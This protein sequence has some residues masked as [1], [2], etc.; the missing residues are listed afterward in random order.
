MPSLAEPSLHLWATN[1]GDFGDA[2]ALLGRHGFSQAPPTWYYTEAIATRSV[3]YVHRERPVRIE[4]HKVDLNHWNR[5]PIDQLAVY[6]TEDRPM[7]LY[8]DDQLSRELILHLR[9]PPRIA[10]HLFDQWWRSVFISIVNLVR[11]GFTVVDQG[12]PVFTELLR[13]WLSTVDHTN[14]VRVAQNAANA[15]NLLLSPL[16]NNA[17][18]TVT[19][20][21]THVWIRLDDHQ[22]I[23]VWS[24][25]EEAALLP[26][27]SPEY[28]WSFDSNRGHNRIVV[29]LRNLMGETYLAAL[30]SMMNPDTC[31]ISGVK[32]FEKCLKEP[33][34]S[35]GW[36]DVALNIWTTTADKYNE[37]VRLLRRFARPPDSDDP[38]YTIEM[39]VAI[40]TTVLQVVKE[41]GIIEDICVHRT[42]TRGHCLKSMP[43][44]Q[45]TVIWDNTNIITYVNSVNAPVD[46]QSDRRLYLKQVEVEH[47]HR[48]TQA[49]SRPNVWMHVLSVVM[50]TLLD[51]G[52]TATRFQ[53]NTYFSIGLERLLLLE[54]NL[55]TAVACTRAAVRDFN[56]TFA[57]RVAPVWTATVQVDGYDVGVVLASPENPNL[58]RITVW[59][60]EGSEGSEDDEYDL[61][62]DDL[63]NAGQAMEVEQ[64]LHPVQRANVRNWD[65][66]DHTGY[67]P[68]VNPN[69]DDPRTVN[70]PIDEMNPDLGD[71]AYS[72][73]AVPEIDVDMRDKDIAYPSDPIRHAVCK[74]LV[75]DEI[76]SLNQWLLEDPDDNIIL[77]TP[78]VDGQ[79]WGSQALCYSRSIAK[80]ALNDVFSVLFK[81]RDPP[82]IPATALVAL[83]VPPYKVYVP[84]KDIAYI[85]RA[86]RVKVFQVRSTERVI[87][88]SQSLAFV[89][90]LP[91]SGV[92]GAHC[93]DD[94]DITVS[95]IK[96]VVN[97]SGAM[98]RRLSH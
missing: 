84:T 60:E 31:W 92:S 10:G 75:M 85:I 68:D 70:A 20:T 91:N 44:S 13:P 36:E 30:R 56:E 7:H 22:R 3:G 53:L 40:E 32:V 52:L 64:P 8:P 71:D 26:T 86:T 54:E 72:H 46:V 69:P 78:S 95:R 34:T 9:E 41:D 37:V 83:P 94:T 42:S 48:P 79:R 19:Y 33:H 35:Q 77:L 97:R 80:N 93:Q 15:Y 21:A 16:F 2:L 90:H 4:V 51:N 29:Y 6:Y 59:T 17:H 49:S 63:M 1:D 57:A 74:D 87:S 45:L 24:P 88:P 38:L 98:R 62:A 28:Q 47:Y 89:R 50:S 76:S 58:E 12:A 96:G 18:A 5:H 23:F 73:Y 61:D 81:C 55:T 43:L 14:A 82:Y 65:D 39:M 11:R 27:S 25:G 67:H 66:N